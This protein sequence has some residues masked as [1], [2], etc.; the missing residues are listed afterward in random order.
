MLFIT[1]EKREL[2]KRAGMWIRTQRRCR[3]ALTGTAGLADAVIR[4]GG[5]SKV[6][7]SC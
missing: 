1:D 5:G 6:V 3:E 2:R 7:R 4:L